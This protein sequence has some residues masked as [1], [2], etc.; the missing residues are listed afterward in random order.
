LSWEWLTNVTISVIVEVLANGGT[1]I[2]PRNRVI[3]K[4]PVSVYNRLKSTGRDFTNRRAAEQHGE[5]GA[6]A[7]RVVDLQAGQKGEG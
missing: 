2:A 7:G 5:G 1:G 4:N 6:A 3:P